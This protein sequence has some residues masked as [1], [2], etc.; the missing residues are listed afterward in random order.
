MLVMSLLI[1]KAASIAALGTRKLAQRSSNRYTHRRLQLTNEVDCEIEKD[2]VQEDYSDLDLGTVTCQ[3]VNESQEWVIH[4]AFDCQVCHTNWECATYT[5][6][7]TSSFHSSWDCFE[8]SSGDKVCELSDDSGIIAL[9][10]NGESCASVNLDT[11]CNFTPSH[12]YNCTNLGEGLHSECNGGRGSGTSPY[13]DFVFDN[14]EELCTV[15]ECTD[16][17]PDLMFPLKPLLSTRTPSPTLTPATSMPLAPIPTASLPTGPATTASSCFNAHKELNDN[18]I[19]VCQTASLTTSEKLTGQCDPDCQALLTAVVENCRKGDVVDNEVNYVV[20]YQ[21]AFLFHEYHQNQFTSTWASCDFGYE[22]TLCDLAYGN[23]DISRSS[24]WIFEQIIENEDACL[25]ASNEDECSAECISYIDQVVLH[26]DSP[27]QAFFSPNED[28]FERTHTVLEWNHVESMTRLHFN[29]LSEDF[30]YEPLSEPC[31]QYYETK[32]EQDSPTSIYESSTPAEP[33]FKEC[34]DAFTELDDSASFGACATENQCTANCQA[35]IDNVQNSCNEGDA[36]DIDY[37]GPYLEYKGSVLYHEF[38]FDWI[39]PISSLCRYGE[40]QPTS[41]DIA[42]GKLLRNLDTITEGICSDTF[43]AGSATCSPDCRNIV[44]Q[45]VN[46]CDVPTNSTFSP[47]QK[48]EDVDLWFTAIPWV[49]PD[50]MEKS[51]FSPEI[52]FFETLTEPC[53]DYYKEQV[54]LTFSAVTTGTPTKVA[55]N[56]PTMGPTPSP[57]VA[58]NRPSNKLPSVAPVQSP[59]DNSTTVAPVQLPSSNS[60]TVAPVQSPSARDIVTSDVSNAVLG[61]GSEW[62]GLFGLFVLVIY[63]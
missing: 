26:C 39:S 42:Y 12:I 37:N 30:A 27:E 54:K 34:R 63:L 2:N 31:W 52:D 10:I 8:F 38:V 36:L 40:F 61:F 5:F 9:M 49:F 58:T 32:A 29:P 44:E 56:A 46:D 1:L 11:T 17:P 24:I 4:C 22:P 57:I 55:T 23:L 3:C 16:T 6:E 14:S 33:Y 20:P 21:P 51:G 15:G 7:E 48:Y 43:E 50:S 35:L 47:G 25:S 28:F 53:W 45:I 59:F 13:W 62:V 18:E 19:S 60:P 41:C